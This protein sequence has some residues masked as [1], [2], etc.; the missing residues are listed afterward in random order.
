MFSAPSPPPLPAP[1]PPPAN[2]PMYGSD[3]TRGGGVGGRK[4]G[5]TGFGSPTILGGALG[6]G[7]TG[8]PGTLLGA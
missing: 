8:T 4:P 5:T 6:P 2:P 3:A 1:P 7:A